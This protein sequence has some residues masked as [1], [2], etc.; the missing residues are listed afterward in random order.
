MTIKSFKSKLNNANHKMRG[1]VAQCETARDIEPI[2]DRRYMSKS[3]KLSH[4]MGEE[5]EKEFGGKLRKM[6]GE[7][8]TFEYGKD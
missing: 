5:L 1:G 4:E 8:N 3:E 7:K 6:K 2:P